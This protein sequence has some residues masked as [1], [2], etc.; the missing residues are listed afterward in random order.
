MEK[1]EPII[2]VTADLRHLNIEEMNKI[3]IFATLK[4]L[5]GLGKS[6]I[7]NS[8]LNYYTNY[9]REL[10]IIIFDNEIKRRFFLNLL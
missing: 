7:Y 9:T 3:H 5:K 2:W 8:H 6:I 1:K 4:C 10:W